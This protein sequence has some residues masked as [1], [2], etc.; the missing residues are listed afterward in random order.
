MVH[1]SIILKL[2]SIS[3]LLQPQRPGELGSSLFYPDNIILLHERR[4]L[5]YSAYGLLSILFSM[6]GL[7]LIMLVTL[8]RLEGYLPISSPSTVPTK[9]MALARR[10]HLP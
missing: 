8:I 3:R 2:F 10:V 9:P 5:K 4:T 7:A 6:N 1:D